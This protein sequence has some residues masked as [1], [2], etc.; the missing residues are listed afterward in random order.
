DQ[1]LAVTVSIGFAEAGDLK[2]GDAKT[3]DAKAPFALTV[4]AAYRALYEVKGEGGNRVK[5]GTVSADIPKIGQAATN[6]VVSF[7]D[8]QQ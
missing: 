4:K 3:G 2:T 1:A 5:R 8:F 7:S 6:R